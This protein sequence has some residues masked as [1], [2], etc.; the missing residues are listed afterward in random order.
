MTSLEDDLSDAS[1]I[2]DDDDKNADA[3]SENEVLHAALALVSF[4][5]LE[6]S[7][8]SVTRGQFF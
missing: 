5:L 7:V 1:L 8:E 2:E 3:E 4:S 6:R